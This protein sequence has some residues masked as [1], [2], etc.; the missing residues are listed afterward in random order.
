MMSVHANL[1]SF[2]YIVGA[3]YSI[4]L[5]HVYINSLFQC[6]ECC[7]YSII[8]VHAYI[9]I[10]KCNQCGVVTDHQQAMKHCL[11]FLDNWY[12]LCDPV[13]SILTTGNRE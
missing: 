1:T 6:I 8:L 5:V 13:T 10:F 11:S 2:R 4:I 9:I 3:I 12:K 7:I